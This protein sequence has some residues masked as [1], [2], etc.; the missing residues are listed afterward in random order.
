M[1]IFNTSFFAQQIGV[2]PQQPAPGMLLQAGPILPVQVQVPAALAQ[3]LQ[4]TNQAIP[5]PIAGIALVDTGA[6]MSAVEVTVVQ[7]LGIQPVGTAVVGTAGGKQM[8]AVYPARF[9]FPGTGLPHIDCS[10]LFGA[11]LLGI[12]PA[13]GGQPLIALIGRDILTQFVLV[14]NGPAATF[15]LCF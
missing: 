9:S 5:T 15:S 11:S 14:Y 2:P 3:Q 4:A 12:S 6:T 10:S 13:G 1:P 7:S 8:Q